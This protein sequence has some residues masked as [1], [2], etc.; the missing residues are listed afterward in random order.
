[1]T[2]LSTRRR[3]WATALSA[4]ALVAVP[5]GSTLGSTL[6]AHAADQATGVVHTGGQAL[7]VRAQ[8]T[9]A[10]AAVG[11]RANGSTVTIVCQA[12]GQT[13]DGRYG[14]TS[15]WDRLRSGGFVSDAFVHTGSDGLVAPLCEGS[16]QPTP[17]TRRAKVRATVAAAT[18]MTGR[19]PYSWGGGS[20]AGPTTGICCSP[21]GID[22]RRTVGFDCSGLMEYAFHQG[23]GLR[24]SSTSRSQYADGPRVPISRLEAG[25]LVFW[26]PSA[27]S[28]SSIHHVALYAG[29]GRVVEATRVD[30][31]DIRVRSFSTGEPGLMPYAVRPIP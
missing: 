23:S 15:V 29:D 21:S 6:G 30:G 3:R 11:S 4:V 12:Y 10:S 1:M 14:R 31:P 2:I 24:L 9:S 16:G 22:D 28:P 25:D 20:Y 7:T 8:P 13:V 17:T 26:G 18:S 19:Y 5:L 27:T